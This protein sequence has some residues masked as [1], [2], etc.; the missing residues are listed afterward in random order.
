ME[1]FSVGIPAVVSNV[2]GVSEIVDSSNGISLDKNFTP[3][4]LM[5]SIETVMKNNESLSVGAYSSWQASYNEGKNY[6]SFSVFSQQ[7]CLKHI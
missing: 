7:S 2:G 3:D 5:T 4:E 6:S 1:A